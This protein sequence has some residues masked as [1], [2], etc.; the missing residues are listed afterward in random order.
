MQSKGILTAD[1]EYESGFGGCE[2][3]VY[4]VN[5]KLANL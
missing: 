5:N 2:P 3:D 4:F 1:E